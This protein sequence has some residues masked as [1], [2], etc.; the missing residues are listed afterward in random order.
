[1]FD[2]IPDL[3]RSDFASCQ[4]F[5]KNADLDNRIRTLRAKHRQHPL[6]KEAAEYLHL[7]VNSKTIHTQKENLKKYSSCK[8]MMDK[9]GY[10][11]SPRTYTKRE[12]MLLNALTDAQRASRRLDYIRR[13]HAEFREAERNGWF[14]IFDTLTYATPHLT[15][16]KRD[17]NSHVGRYC[18]TIGECVTRAVHGSL[19]Y[20][21]PDPDN[22][23]RDKRAYHRVRD[24]YRYFVV[25]EYGDKN[26]R[27]HFHVVHFCRGLPSSWKIDPMRAPD[28]KNRLIWEM[29]KLWNY[30][31]SYPMTARYSPRD[32]WGRLGHYWPRQK[33]GLPMPTG[34]LGKLGNYLTKYIQKSMAEKKKGDFPW[35][36]SMTR[37]FGNQ[38]IPHLIPNLDQAIQ[39]LD[40][41][42]RWKLS[43]LKQRHNLLPSKSLLRRYAMKKLAAMYEPSQIME[44]QRTLPRARNILAELPVKSLKVMLRFAPNPITSGK[45]DASLVPAYRKNRR[46]INQVHLELD[47]TRAEI[48]DQCPNLVTLLDHYS[49]VPKTTIANCGG[50]YGRSAIR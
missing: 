36:I 38:I 39:Y 24:N 26:G 9:F 37:M 20:Y 13:L 29:K 48:R 42:L 4:T 5:I 25:P 17:G 35:R 6:H 33:S 40:G 34:T 44:L 23:H 7:L 50:I 31:F 3:R 11:R 18:R 41:R 21:A 1:M 19:S 8:D 32:A 30:G 12:K 46:D 22:I 28:S 2:F 47:R 43:Q 45:F 49:I 16:A 14:V 10:H 15:A 27:I